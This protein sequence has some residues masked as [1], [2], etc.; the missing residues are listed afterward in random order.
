MKQSR[1]KLLNKNGEKIIPRKNN[2]GGE[3]GRKRQKKKER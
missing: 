2:K 3:E 1:M